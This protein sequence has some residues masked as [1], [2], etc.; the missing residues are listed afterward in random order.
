[1]LAPYDVRLAGLADSYPFSNHVF[2]NKRQLELK[3][4]TAG[5][6]RALRNPILSFPGGFHLHDRRVSIGLICDHFPAACQTRQNGG[7]GSALREKHEAIT[8][9]GLSSATICMIHGYT[10]TAAQG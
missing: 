9:I 3:S 1:L 5:E 6:A 4:R 7:F 2:L 10:F 8:F